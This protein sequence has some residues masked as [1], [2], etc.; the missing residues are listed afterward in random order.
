MDNFL[1]SVNQYVW[2]VPMLVLI[3]GTGIYISLR[4][5]FVQVRLF[6]KSVKLFIDQLRAPEAS[7]DKT[8]PFRALC[9]ALAATVGTGN[10]AGVAGAIAVGGPGAI[11]WMWVSAFLGM[12]VKFAEAALSVRYRSVDTNGNVRGGPMYSIVNGM[13]PKWRWLALV[14]SFFGVVAAFGVGNATQIN[15]L[16]VSVDGVIESAG[17]TVGPQWNLLMGVFL[18]ILIGTMLLGGARRIG[19]V[20]EKLV[21]FAGALYV[22]MGIGVLAVCFRRIPSAFAQI[23]KGAFCPSAI[24][25]G[26]VGSA[27]RAVRVGTSRGVFT[28]EA[29]MGTA[30]IAH[31]SAECGHPVQ[32]GCMGIIEVFI[33]TF[34][35]CTIT[36]LVILCSGVVIPYG[37]DI[38]VD[39]TS[40][41]FSSIYGTWI[42]IPIALAICAFALATVIGWGLY[43]ARCAQFL[44]GER[45]WKPF[46]L[47]QCF[48]VVAGSLMGTG[49]IWLLAETV[50]GLMAIPNLIC[51]SALVPELVRLVKEYNK[52]V[53]FFS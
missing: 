12:A 29:G 22:I 24:T 31:G 21:P 32:Q 11:F 40:Q 49:A 34:V 47:L 51:I 35:I 25:G 44:I 5:K 1:I 45:A 23:V 3:L 46:V 4:T 30:G 36:A 16:I 52:S 43:G 15:T 19:M 8:S 42:R 20:A 14:Y 18:A 13:G 33:D 41:A 6:P 26:V 53:D 17:M 28:N 48:T 37:K 39:L 9:T 38:G 27:I 10:L 7:K 50:N 2:G